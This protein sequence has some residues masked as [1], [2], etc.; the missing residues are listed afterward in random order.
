MMHTIGGLLAAVVGIA[1]AHVGAWQPW[2][3]D[4]PAQR[5]QKWLE[6]Q[7]QLSRIRG[8]RIGY[9]CL[10]DRTVR[11]WRPLSGSIEFA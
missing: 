10:A 11:G 4:T 1:I 2:F 8:V 6:D 7:L 5:C 3:A 9:E